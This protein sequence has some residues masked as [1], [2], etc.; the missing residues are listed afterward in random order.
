MRLD[1]RTASAFSLERSARAA[2]D[3][4]L[5]PRLPRRAAPSSSPFAPAPIPITTIRPLVSRAATS[6]PRLGAPNQLEDYVERSAV[7]EVV[8]RRSGSSPSATLPGCAATLTGLSPSPRTSPA[9]PSSTRRCPHAV[10]LSVDQQL[11]PR[12]EAGLGEQR[13]VG[14]REDLG[15]AAGG[16]PVERLRHGHRCAPVDVAGHRT[17]SKKTIAMTRSPSSKRC[18]PGR[19]SGDPAGQPADRARRRASRAAPQ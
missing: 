18:A 1:A 13:V 8:V 2:L 11:L 4:W 12:T 16:R 6:A 9:R 5:R 7:G 15:P 17:S 19:V 3:A 14:G 10:G